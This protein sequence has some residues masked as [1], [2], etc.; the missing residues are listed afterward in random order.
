V[1]L[2]CTNLAV[3]IAGK[4]TSRSANHLDIR[5]RAPREKAHLRSLNNHSIE[6]EGE[7]CMSAARHEL[8]V[9]SQKSE[10]SNRRI[11]RCD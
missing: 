9:G 3:V 5:Y 1:W 10:I 4:Q 8:F 2:F 7:N 11:V 6:R